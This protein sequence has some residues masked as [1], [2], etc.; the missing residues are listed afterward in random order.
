MNALVLSSLILAGPVADVAD[1]AGVK[2]LFGHQSVGGNLLE[3]VKQQGT[4]T[5]MPLAP[6]APPLGGLVLAET[7]V[8]RNVD[9][10]SKLKDF[11]R[12]VSEHAGSLDG[13]MFKLCYID[14][15]QGTDV[16]ALFDKYTSMMDRLAQAHPKLLIAHITTPL[17]IVQSGPKAWLK[18]VFG[19]ARWGYVENQKR[20][21]WNALLKKR[22]ASKAP[23]FDLADL[24]SRTDDGDPV[25]YEVDGKRFPMLFAGYTDDGG[26]LN[27][28]AKKKIGQKLTEF[29]L[30]L[31]AIR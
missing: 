16:P 6:G 5:V 11:E 29:V 30:H 26:H 24:E 12:L 7:L 28:K 18:S 10:E 2:I 14:F 9:P 4:V 3:G 25:S 17:T 31:R 27:E 19:K 15:N 21:E 13:A 23:I 20:A 22:Y 1:P 8:G